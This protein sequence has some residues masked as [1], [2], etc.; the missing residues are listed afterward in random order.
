MRGKTAMKG[1][2]G[3]V[4]IGALVA[5]GGAAMV[6]L[7][8]PLPSRVQVDATLPDQSNPPKAAATQAP[9]ASERR[10][11][12]LVEAAPSIPTSSGTEDASPVAVLDTNPG[13]RPVVATAEGA[14]PGDM[15]QGAGVQSLPQVPSTVTAETESGVAPNAPAQEQGPVVSTETAAVPAPPVSTETTTESAPMESLPLSEQAAPS[16]G[17]GGEGDSTTVRVGT[18]ITEAP[19]MGADSPAVEAADTETADATQPDAGQ[20]RPGITA[21]VVAS[22]S[23]SGSLGPEIGT[24]PV[25]TALPSISATA[26]TPPQPEGGEAQ[27]EVDPSQQES[28]AALVADEEA[29]EQQLASAEG[30]TS[31]GELG[32]RLGT[33]VVPLTERSST[34][35]LI[36]GDDAAPSKAVLA[37]GRPFEINAE[38]F[39]ALDNRPLMSIVLI[40]DA[41]AIG[42]E[43]L[44]DFPYPLTFAISPQDPK[45]AEK[46][47]ARRA[48]GF[49]VLI[50]ADLPREATPQDAETA[51][52]VWMQQLPQ[53]V[54]IL[55]GVDT[56]FQGNR[57]LA[58]QMVA[59]MK[60]T[61]YGMVTQ[62][63]GLNTVQKLALRDG[64]PAGV[65]FRD[66]D[67]AGQ[68]PRAIRR[69]LDQAAFRARQEGAVIMLGRLR[70]DTISALLL[71][72]LQ[73]RASQ[74]G[75][76]P[77]SAGLKAA[78][79]AAD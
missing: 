35:T 72:G 42:A 62:N 26:V 10:D 7:S 5:V 19:G 76:A 68:N 40:D 53:A 28:A 43:A 38:A 33:R 2:L 52:G 22:P 67:G 50:L 78:I 77:I 61:G 29:D 55:E 8:S 31:G 34:P 48:A 37:D 1:F 25:A 14:S 57:P 21:P 16:Q 15:S 45:A 36:A 41:A 73:D 24:A 51:M 3:G 9:E 12:D 39:V 65:V 49:E 18:K 74:V 47:K 44:Q 27:A 46:M 63:S 20:P 58:D 79:P 23:V 6:S 59:V 4:S 60:A 70:P 66:F 56:G 30:A 17:V 75:L 71:W 69:F 64:M 11:A 13:S 32:A 54:G